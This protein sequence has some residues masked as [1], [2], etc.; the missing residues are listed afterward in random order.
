M[1]DLEK[2]VR[3]NIE[4]EIATTER[5]IRLEGDTIEK[6]HAEFEMLADRLSAWKARIVELRDRR[7]RLIESLDA[8]K[9]H[10]AK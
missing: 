4:R 6:C 1:T 5:M 2:T 7:K 9:E 3:S 10:G 8:R